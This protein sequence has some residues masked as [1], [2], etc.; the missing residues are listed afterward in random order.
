MKKALL[1]IL[2]YLNVY[3]QEKMNLTIYT[4]I[5]DVTGVELTPK[6][7]NWYMSFF[8]Q[9]SVNRIEIGAAMGML[10]S[11]D[12]YDIGLGIRTGF[13]HIDDK[14]IPYYGV[15]IDTDYNTSKRFFIGIKAMFNYLSYNDAVDFSAFD[16]C[17]KFGIKF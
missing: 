4:D 5:L 8:A 6:F 16:I 12:D 15:Q 10:G 11:I 13:S 3:S 9:N 2:L 7:E 14:T 1:I 17:F